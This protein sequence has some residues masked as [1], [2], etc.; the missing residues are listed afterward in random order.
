MKLSRLIIGL[1]IAGTFWS[2]CDDD[3]KFKKNPVD[4]LIRDMA[5][6]STFT[7]I[8]HDMN[9]IDEWCDKYQHQYRI[10]KEK[11]GKLVETKTKWY[12]VSE[13]FFAKNENNM[14]MELAAK[15]KDGKV[16]KQVAPAGY[17]NYVGNQKYGQWK[18]NS[19]GTSF[20]EF[21]GKYALISSMFNMMSYPAYYSHYNDY[22][23]NYASSGRSYYGPKDS[24]G[25]YRY[26]TYSTYN[27][28]T[29]S[30]SKWNSKPSNRSFSKSY[31]SGSRSGSLRGRGG[32]S[33]K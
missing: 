3:S 23:R 31:R 14:G 20:W 17:S 2:C 9:V 26:G 30:T 12:E 15:T 27:Q 32:S 8:L 10:I 21:Y 16:K 29:R 4:I 28:K 25:N 13:K 1:I 7:I 18:Q 19:N 33:G 5:K 22:R 6:D 24:R 11:E